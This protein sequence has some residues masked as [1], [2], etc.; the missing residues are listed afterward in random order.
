MM[1][2]GDRKVLGADGVMECDDSDGE[3]WVVMPEDVVMGIVGD[4]DVAVTGSLTAFSNYKTKLIKLTVK[5]IPV[6]VV[7]VFVAVNRGKVIAVG[8]CAVV[9]EDQRGMWTR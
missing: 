9:G 7:F 2:F 3:R 5:I 6:V 8:S 4:D 1:I